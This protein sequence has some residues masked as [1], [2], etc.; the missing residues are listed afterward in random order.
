VASAVVMLAVGVVMAVRGAGP[1]DGE[2]SS[3]FGHVHG[4]GMDPADAALYAG[5]HYGLFR[6][7]EDGGSSACRRPAVGDQLGMRASLHMVLE[8]HRI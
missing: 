4:L 8:A 2:S 6:I 1:S 7:S 5:T 3:A